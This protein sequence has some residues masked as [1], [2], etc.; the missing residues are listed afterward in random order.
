MSK[1]SPTLPWASVQQAKPLEQSKSWKLVKQVVVYAPVFN[2]FCTA[3][4]R[5]FHDESAC[6]GSI[7][8][9]FATA[10]TN[11]SGKS[12]APRLNIP[13][14]RVDLFE[15][16]QT[17]I[18]DK[19]RSM[20]SSLGDDVSTVSPV[21]LSLRLHTPGVILCP[22]NIEF[23]STANYGHNEISAVE[24]ICQ[25]K[26]L[27]LYFPGR[28]FQKTQLDQLKIFLDALRDRK[29]QE[30]AFDHARHGLV[31]KDQRALSPSL[32]P[33]PY[34]GHPASLQGG[35]IHPPLYSATSESPRVVGKRRRGTILLL[36]RPPHYVSVA[37]QYT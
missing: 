1:T 31:Q 18:S 22:S 5:I 15:L 4:L 10:C 3:S 11:R 21:S 24:M 13:P 23:P 19:L 37:Y 16:C 33:P 35:E 30:K 25:S 36:H 6:Q 34:S 28:D 12:Q 17:E 2:V 9:H 14:E 26:F 8:L 20:L 29:L 7:F 32:D 27:R